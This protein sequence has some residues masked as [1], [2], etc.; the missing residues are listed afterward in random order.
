MNPER[1]VPRA[2][3]WTAAIW[4]R[5]SSWAPGA[6][7]HRALEQRRDDLQPVRRRPQA[8]QRPGHRDIFNWVV[9]IAS[10]S[11][12]DGGLYTASRMLFALAREG[13]FPQRLARTQ[14]RRKV[15]TL[16][17]LITSLC[18]SSA[19]CWR[20]STRQRLRV[21]G[22][23]LVVR[24]PLRLA[25]DPD[26]P[27]AL[28][29]P[30]APPTPARCT[31]SPAVP[32]DPGRGHR[33]RAR[34]LRGPVLLRLRDH[35]RADHDPRQR[36]HRRGRPDLDRLWALYYL[37][38][39]APDVHA[40]ASTWRQPGDGRRR[41][42]APDAAA[43][44]RYGDRLARQ[45]GD[46]RSRI[47]ARTDAHAGDCDARY[48]GDVLKVRFFPWRSRAPRAARSPTSD[49][50]QYLDFMAGWAVANT[51]YGTPEI[52]DRS[53]RRCARPRSAPSPR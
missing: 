35:D 38:Y 9:I 39:R 24:L 17:I 1:D 31:G 21:R 8:L 33:R 14:P 12:V 5:C 28:P 16:A 10:L 6:D 19:P 32:A 18:I 40:T 29:P 7:G 27:D 46:R 15:P 44:T 52:L 2:L 47:R 51:G 36:A 48:L 41:A 13:Y 3:M 53:W 22:Q 50:Q 49:G 42:T 45:V 25:D 4:S 26:R 34:R 30:A 43:P 37:A 23:P 11:S 20:S